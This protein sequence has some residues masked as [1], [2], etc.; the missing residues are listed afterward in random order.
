MALSEKERKIW[1]EAHDKAYK[2]AYGEKY[3]EIMADDPDFP[4]K[5]AR[6]NASDYAKEIADGA[7]EDAVKSSR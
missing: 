3:A 2:A 4:E 5:E 6:I 7:A 1:R